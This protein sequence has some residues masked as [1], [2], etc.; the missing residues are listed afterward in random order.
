MLTKE[1]LQNV[2]DYLYEK[3]TVYCTSPSEKNRIE[4]V[5]QLYSHNMNEELYLIL[6]EGRAEGLFEH[7]FFE[8]DLQNSFSKL[9]EL[10]EKISDPE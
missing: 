4:R 10:I 7:R 2:Y 6:N 8:R 1:Y 3:W 5:V 9:T